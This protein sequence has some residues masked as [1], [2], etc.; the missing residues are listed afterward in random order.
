MA[1]VVIDIIDGNIGKA[2]YQGFEFDRIA[3]VHDVSGEAWG[4]DDPA[5]NKVRAAILHDDIPNL[6]DAHPSEPTA[7]LYEIAAISVDRDIVKLRLKYRT[8]QGAAWE[9]GEATIIE[10]ATTLVQKEANVDI[11][12]AEIYISHKYPGDADY[13]DQGVLVPVTTPQETVI[14]R[15]RETVDPHTFGMNYT[16]KVNITPWY[17]GAIGTWLCTMITGRSTNRTVWWD[18]AYSFQ[19]DPFTWE[20]HAVFIDPNT[21]RP[22]KDIEAGVGE[23][24]YR[25]YGLADFDE[26]DLL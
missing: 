26:L 1:N 11:D 10:A 18:N 14:F 17:G 9:L 16:N 22:P 20:H 5:I 7:L 12:G 2:T 3:T 6:G 4:I 15:K 21:G 19:Y 24:Y 23:K 13:K 8:T 25:M